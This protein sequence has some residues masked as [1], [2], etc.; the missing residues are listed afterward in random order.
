MVGVPCRKP[1][2]GTISAIG[3][4]AREIVWSMPLSPIEEMGQADHN[5]SRAVFCMS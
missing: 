3:L 4:A 2:Y 5:F 1:F